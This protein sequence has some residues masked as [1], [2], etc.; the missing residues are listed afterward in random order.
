MTA[1]ALSPADLTV[2]ALLVVASAALSIALSLGVQ[3]P[4]L[5]AAARMVLQL[6]LVGLILRWIFASA[7]A[8]ITS[9]GE[10][11]AAGLQA[12]HDRRGRAVSRVSGRGL[13]E[14]VR[15]DGGIRPVF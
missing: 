10:D 3:R 5:I 15:S 14:R 1:V 4:L 8:A 13:Q 12:T 6:A 11:A 9:A 2:A 7:S